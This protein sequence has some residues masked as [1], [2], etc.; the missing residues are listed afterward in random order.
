VKKPEYEKEFYQGLKIPLWNDRCMLVKNMN[1]L[2][3]IKVG[4]GL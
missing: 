2:G 3:A 1:M 4:F